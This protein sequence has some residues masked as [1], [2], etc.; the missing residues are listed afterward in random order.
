MVFSEASLDDA[1]LMSNN[2]PLN[3]LESRHADADL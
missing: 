1:L 3:Y 2:P